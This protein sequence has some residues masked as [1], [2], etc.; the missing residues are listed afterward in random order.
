MSPSTQIAF[1]AETFPCLKGREIVVCWDANAV[2]TWACCGASHG[3]KLAARFVLSV[4]D[5]NHQWECGR[6]DVLEAYGAW[7]PE[8]WQ[9]FQAWV[10]E[11]F[12][13]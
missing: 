11:P 7:D 2:D 9:A 4:W 12:T 8:H 3:Q 13:V 5:P 6:F 1:L 10:K